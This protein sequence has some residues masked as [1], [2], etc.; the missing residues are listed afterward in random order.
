MGLRR[1]W[2]C[3]A[4]LCML[5]AGCTQANFLDSI[6]THD[7]QS[8]ARTTIDQLRA[9]N[10][11]A[12]EPTLDPSVFGAEPR[13]LLQEMA[14]HVPA[15][16]PKSV[17]LI[18][19]FRQISNGVERLNLS[20]EYEYASSWMLANVATESRAGRRTIIGFNIYPRTQSLE[21]E[22]RFRLAGKPLPHYLVLAA[23]V[24]A[25]AFSVAVAVVCLF[26]R[27][28]PRRWL[29]TLASLVGLTQ[30]AFNWTTGQWDFKLFFFNVP[31]VG[32]FAPVYGPWMVTVA[33]PVG[34]AIALVKRARALRRA[35]APS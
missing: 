5:L 22:H 15:E 23:A 25:G 33:L 26:T 31:P 18:G 14:A 21:D 2:C 4:V 7:Q 27:A 20:F 10:F 9:R 32:A 11:I 24:A 6:A 3:C 1:W 16:A 29:W 34:A 28:L 12:I 35:A 19:A 30:F 13:V 17:K 8:A